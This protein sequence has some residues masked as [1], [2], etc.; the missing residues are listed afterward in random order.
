MS[1]RVLVAVS[2]D[3]EEDN[4]APTSS[5][6]T[7]ENIRAVP[8]LRELCGSLGLRPTFFTTFAVAS[9]PWA[10]DTVRTAAAALSGEVGAHLHPWNT[11]PLDGAGTMLNN[12]PQA[13]QEAKLRAL[14]ER[15]LAGPDGAVP[16]VFR[17]GRFGLGPATVRALLA[18]GYEVD[19]SVTPFFTWENY[20]HGP[21]FVGAP[22]HAYRVD[23]S[24][25]VRIPVA[26]GGVVEVPLSSGYT[27]FSPPHWPAVARGLGRPSSRRMHL[28]GIGARLGIIR[29]VILSPETNSVRQMVALARRL[30]EFGVPHLHLFFHSSS[31]VPGLSPFCRSGADVDRLLSRVC[32]FVERVAALAEVR[33]AR[34]TE[35]ADAA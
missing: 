13:V 25:D 7:V 20:D 27:R 21:T 4:W 18:C 29:R 16:R 23:G 31:L 12:Y 34:V 30:V 19:S 14:T 22:L 17:A 3:T 5:G 11:P 6:L 35:V 1:R 24:S 26:A 15:F 8:R 10:L 33:P 28:A 9:T 32:D 2:V